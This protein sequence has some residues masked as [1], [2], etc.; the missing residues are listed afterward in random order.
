[1]TV[2]FRVLQHADSYVHSHGMLAQLVRMS[3]YVRDPSKYISNHT[4]AKLRGQII[5]I[6]E[7]IIRVRPETAIRQLE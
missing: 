1:M 5:I 4:V 7:L 6:V 3:L 2:T